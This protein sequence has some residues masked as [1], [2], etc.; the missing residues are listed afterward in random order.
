MNEEL[1]RLQAIV[2]E[3][4]IGELTNEQFDRYLELLDREEEDEIHG[5]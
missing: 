4:G 3:L 1:E 2:D 5:K